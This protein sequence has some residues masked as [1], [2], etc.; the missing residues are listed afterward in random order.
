MCEEGAVF[1]G[2][3]TRL[4]RVVKF[5]LSSASCSEWD[6]GGDT[7]RDT[8]SHQDREWAEEGHLHHHF[9]DTP[10]PT[11]KAMGSSQLGTLLFSGNV[12]DNKT[13]HPLISG[14]RCREQLVHTRK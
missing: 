8:G 6:R 11:N 4:T 1:S 10:P 14:E 3:V 7:G 5:I 2:K 12:G 13:Y 9:T